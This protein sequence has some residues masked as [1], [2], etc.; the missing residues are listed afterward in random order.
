MKR[1]ALAGVEGVELFGR[2][3]DRIV[4]ELEILD[5]ALRA[6]DPTL[7]GAVETSRQKM[8]HQVESL[9]TKFVNAEARRNETLERHLETIYNSVYP[10]KKLQERVIN[11]TSFLVRYGPGFIAWLDEVLSLD[12]TEHQV[13]EI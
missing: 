2:L 5:A 9:R 3:R 12:S 11:T 13:V 1:K 6:V 4:G 10:E 7:A 8:L